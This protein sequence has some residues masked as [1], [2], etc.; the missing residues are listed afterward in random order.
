TIEDTV[1]VGKRRYRVA[2][3]SAKHIVVELGAH[4]LARGQRAFV[5][6]TPHEVRSFA[7]RPA[8]PSLH[9]FE[10]KWV[11][12]ERPAASQRPKFVPLGTPEDP[13]R[14]RAAIV[15]DHS[16]TE[17]LSGSALPIARTRL[18]TTLHAE[19]ARALA[20]D[21]DAT[22]ELWQAD[23][24]SLRRGAAS[25]PLLSVRQL[26]LSY[27]GE[28]LQAAIGR[29]RYAATTLGML[30]GARASAAIGE[31][32]AI[33]GFGGTLA[34]PLDTSPEL[35]TQRFGA[36]L[37]YNGE[38]AR[39]PAR[40]SL[41][42][43]GSRFD[44]RLDERRLTAT[45][46][47]YPSFGRLGAR[48]EASMFDSDNP[49][50]ADTAELTA[51]AGDA[52]FR[53]G[54]L[55]FGLALETRRPERS[56]WL[57]SFLPAGYFCVSR[58]VAGSATS[59]PCLGGDLRTLAALTAAW[60]AENWTLDAGASAVTTRMAPAEQATAFVHF[61][62]RNLFGALRF[63]AGSSVSSGSL[64]ESAAL[65][66]G[67]GASL[68]R[69]ALDASVYYR[70]NVLRY[71]ANSEQLLEHGTGAR[72]WWALFDGFDTS[73]SGD[74]LTGPDVDVLFVQAALAW[75]PRF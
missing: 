63:D 41:T 5:W 68:L 27:R 73:L 52:S 49:W 72:L 53:V 3:S 26:E 55:R 25:R 51:L 6:T 30:D 16:R 22:V 58:T 47:S 19:L 67:L 54:S 48:A 12:P 33:A 62:R 8:P 23:D 7:T 65:E 59:E 13:R 43:Q 15:L 11:D 66:V 28:S 38:V 56:Y 10:D 24:L 9:A 32:W 20:F 71:R 70:P 1:H 2:A 31:S 18:R 64:L 50:N 17:P 60:D 21:A 61:Q 35:D 34:D 42:A 57:A 75:R 39:A 44:G 29:L 45:F 74:L 36:E 37:L 69:D 4:P 40:A 14:N 46:E